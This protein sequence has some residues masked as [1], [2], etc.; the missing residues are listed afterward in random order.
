MSKVFSFFNRHL[1]KILWTIAI[2]VWVGVG[3]YYFSTH[4]RGTKPEVSQVTPTLMDNL[5]PTSKPVSFKPEGGIVK[6]VEEQVLTVETEGK[7]T[8][9]TVGASVEAYSFLSS[10]DEELPPVSKEIAL[11]DLKVGDRITL[12][13][14]AE[15]GTLKTIYVEYTE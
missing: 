7:E 2:L 1:A 9:V 4:T 10:L 3:I 12:F 13:Y 5:T 15:D 8:T 6:K 14:D 11:K